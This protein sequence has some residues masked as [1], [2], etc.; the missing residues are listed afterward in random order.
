M[1]VCR[2]FTRVKTRHIFAVVS[3]LIGVPLSRSFAQSLSPAASP[4]SQTTVITLDE[5]IRR[6]QSNEPAFAA[7]LAE[8]KVAAIDRSIARTA[9][10]PSATYHNQALYTEPNGQHNQAGQVGSQPTPIFIAN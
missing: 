2:G 1:P 4:G 3:L 7:A 9:F 8:K 5:A 10:L 6:A